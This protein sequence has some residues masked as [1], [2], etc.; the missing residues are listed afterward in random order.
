MNAKELTANIKI[1]NPLNPG[2]IP[3]QGLNLIGA[4]KESGR[5]GALSDSAILKLKEKAKHC[6][7]CKREISYSEAYSKFIQKYK[8]QNL[9]KNHLSSAPEKSNP[10]L[11]SYYGKN[12][13]T[14]LN[15][16]PKRYLT[17]YKY[18]PIP[19]SLFDSIG[20]TERQNQ[21]NNN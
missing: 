18:S 10:V 16:V 4:A 17:F 7:R 1:K 12:L 14:P 20:A 9:P 15:R 11:S 8:D 21:Y 13:F 2:P 3:G 5:E 6:Y 19:Y